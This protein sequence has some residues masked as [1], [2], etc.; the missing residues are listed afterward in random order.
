MAW[1]TTP[2]WIWIKSSDLWKRLS[3][4]SNLMPKGSKKPCLKI[5]P[6]KIFLG[7][8]PT[9]DWTRDL[10]V[11]GL[12]HCRLSHGDEKFWGKKLLFIKLIQKIVWCLW[13]EV[14]F[15]KTFRLCGS[16]SNA[17][18]LRPK[19]PWFNPGWGRRPKK[20]L[21]RGIFKHGFL[22]PLGIKFEGLDSLFHRSEL[23]IQ[24]HFGVVWLVRGQK[25]AT[26][27]MFLWP[28]H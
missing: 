18:D 9:R 23:F 22:E 7:I 26:I 2:K 20:I 11:W 13:A 6:R 14:F 5:P 17:L 10:S 25:S 4:P 12:T 8:A 27:F 3:K 28:Q 16:V 19:G 21:R 24:I 15:P 1:H